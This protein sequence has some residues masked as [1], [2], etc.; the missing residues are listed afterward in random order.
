MASAR[1]EEF[2]NH[3]H[4]PKDGKFA[5]SRFKSGA[6]KGLFSISKSSKRGPKHSLLGF[7]KHARQSFDSPMVE[8]FY[9]RFHS[10]RDGRFTSGGASSGRAGFREGG[11]G[12]GKQTP[13]TVT[14]AI[15][16]RKARYNQLTRDQQ[17]KLASDVLL[18]NNPNLRS[19]VVGRRGQGTAT[20]ENFPRGDGRVGPSHSVATNKALK[21]AG[22]AVTGKPLPLRNATTGRL[23]PSAVRAAFK[24][25]AAKTT[26]SKRT[27]GSFHGA[28]AGKGLAVKTSK[29]V[30]GRVIQ[31]QSSAGGVP[32]YNSAVGPLARKFVQ[33][34][35]HAIHGKAP[36]VKTHSKTKVKQ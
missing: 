29:T 14:P 13:T 1:V 3:I 26:G 23:N 20:P 7:Q 2:F 32:R 33:H 18:H 35:V 34:R 17:K 28:D 31:H 5:S 8:E 12:A 16:T 21:Q 27:T 19:R 22:H 36:A 9:N 4:G 6:G 30:K 25:G 24:T 10:N 11:H 15:G